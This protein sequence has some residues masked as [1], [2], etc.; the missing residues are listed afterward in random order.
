MPKEFSQWV[1]ELTNSIEDTTWTGR[2]IDQHSGTMTDMQ[3]RMLFANI[4][5][6]YKEDPDLW[7]YVFC[8]TSIDQTSKLEVLGE[9]MFNEFL[10]TTIVV[11]IERLMVRINSGWVP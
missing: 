7:M 4:I 2:C 5:Y 6:D 11:F 10:H 9:E 3:K 8:L 1:S